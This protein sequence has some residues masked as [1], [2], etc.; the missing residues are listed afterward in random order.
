MFNIGYS[1]LLETCGQLLAD[2]VRNMWATVLDIK[3][4]KAFFLLWCTIFLLSGISSNK[5][6]KVLS[7]NLGDKLTIQKTVTEFYSAVQ[8]LELLSIF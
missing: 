2:T 8:K 6:L 1:N 7:N 4:S 5:L 3:S